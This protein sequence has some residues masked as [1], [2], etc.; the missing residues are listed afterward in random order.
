M[1]KILLFVFLCCICSTLSHAQND[2]TAQYECLYRLSFLKDTTNTENYTEDLMVLRL[3]KHQSLF[4]C[5]R[6]YIIDSLLSSDQAEAIRQ[7]MLVN[8]VGKYRMGAVQYNILKNFTTKAID[9]TDNV[10]GERYRYT[11]DLPLFNWEITGE[12]KKFWDYTCQKAICKF[13]GRTYEAWFTTDIPIMDGPWK[14]YGLP[15][16]ILEVSDSEKHYVFTFVG[17]QPSN[18]KIETPHQQYAQTTRKQYLK[19]YRNYTKNPIAFITASTG[20]KITA[21]SSSTKVKKPS[22]GANFAP[23]ECD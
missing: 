17:M 19:A 11:E 2:D 3:N 13:R 15:G 21:V 18:A 4:Y 5:E 10:G 22:S 14:F 16:L 12:Q 7:D 1:R 23:M 9:Y 20:I 8:G 6:S